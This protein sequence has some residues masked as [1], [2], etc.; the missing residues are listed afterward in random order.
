MYLSKIRGLLSQKVVKANQII[1]S[2]PLESPRIK[3]QDM[4][5]VHTTSNNVEAVQGASIVVLGVKPQVLGMVSS[6]L[7]SQIHPTALVLSIVAGASVSFLQ[8]ALNHARIVR[9]IPNLPAQVG[10]GTTVWMAIPEVT[11]EERIKVKAILQSLGEEIA[12]QSENYI[13]MATG[14]SGAGPGFVFLFIEA[15]IDAGV[16]IGF[17][18][19]EAQKLTLQTIA[20]SVELMH[21]SS[22]HPA[23]LRNKVTS[24]GGATSAGIYE[25]EKRGMRTAICDAV[26]AAF[27]RTQELA[28]LNQL[29]ELE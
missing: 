17:S 27:Q 6:V 2:D 25:L 20:G 11:D 13:N 1:A 22:E 29:P 19:V 18:R 14:L 7:K 16:K 5:N 8:K 9:A 12:V 3:M 23:V 26:Y 10:M 4:Y 15:M 24:P 28:E 21:Q